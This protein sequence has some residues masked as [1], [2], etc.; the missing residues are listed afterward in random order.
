MTVVVE[1]RTTLDTLEALV[2]EAAPPALFSAGEAPP[3]RTL[4]DILAATTRRHPTALAVTDGTTALTYRALQTKIE[5]LRTRLAAVGIGVGDRVGIRV[6]S[7]TVDLY[8]SIL[9]VL[10]AGAAYVPVDFDDPDE[11]AALVFAEAEVAAVLGAEREL[12]ML[13]TPGGALG[14]PGLDDD[15]WIIFTSGST[16]KPKGVAVTH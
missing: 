10:A 1:P 15:A 11:R 14:T 6:P 16:G 12:T 13:G 5:A 8:V 9:A 2:A 4:L 3:A 7:G